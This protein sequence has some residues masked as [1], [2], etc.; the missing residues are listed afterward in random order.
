MKSIKRIS[1]GV[2]ALSALLGTLFI[3]AS[4]SSVQAQTT[5][6]ISPNTAAFRATAGNAQT[7]L[8][9]ADGSAQSADERPIFTVAFTSTNCDAPLGGTIHAPYSSTGNVALG[10]TNAA[11][12]PI[13]THINTN[14]TSQSGTGADACRYTLRITSS[15]NCIITVTNNPTG[16]SNPVPVGTQAKDTAT[17]S[18]TNAI[19]VSL[20]GQTGLSTGD[21]FRRAHAAPITADDT[22]TPE[23]TAES[24]S[25]AGGGAGLL[26]LPTGV[27]AP[28][29]L[30]LA[31][32]S[33]TALA[34]VSTM[35]GLTS[36]VVGGTD[37]DAPPTLTGRVAVT[38]AEPQG[39]LNLGLS[40]EPLSQCQSP[41]SGASSYAAGDNSN[42]AF[43][44]LNQNCRY[45]LRITPGTGNVIDVATN[46]LKLQCGVG[47]VIY[48]NS[49]AT[50]LATGS[51]G[52]TPV[53]G[54]AAEA[55]Q[56]R[57]SGSTLTLGTGDSPPQ[58]TKIVLFVTTSCP[59]VATTNLAFAVDSAVSATVGN[60]ASI[61]ATIISATAGCVASP[62]SVTITGAGVVRNVGFIVRPRNGSACQYQVTYPRF[63]GALSL[64]LEPGGSIETVGGVTTV[65]TT[66]NNLDG[67]I[68]INA[69]QLQNVTTTFTYTQRQLDITV[70]TTF[71]DGLVFRTTDTVKYDVSIVGPCSRFP[72]IVARALAN[73]SE[74]YSVQADSGTVI[75]LN[76]Q[77]RTLQSANNQA[78]DLLYEVAPVIIVDNNVV[79][80]TVQVRE[81][82]TP[83]GCVVVT[84]DNGGATKVIEF[85]SGLN[86]FAFDFEH[87][88]TGVE[89][90]SSRGF[91][92]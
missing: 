65:T 51:A 57:F 83:T 20:T 86:A 38:N 30:A 27:P 43:L 75:V 79:N 72:S 48:S 84:D 31:A 59:A 74:S 80:C 73:T 17:G 45:E 23:V 10:V 36:F 50:T 40:I 77:L 8:A 42:V 67:I 14:P 25:V 21:F 87:T 39:S 62:A 52:V 18:Q 90:L 35:N 56:L 85:A 68:A 34:Y 12:I 54:D 60:Q 49:D 41:T 64:Q 81:T 28:G 29:Q 13:V 7:L 26:A 91:T 89:T 15:L 5:T 47:A 55:L 76:K 66:D 9:I 37:C 44:E 92:G 19:S 70:Q 63:S 24:A 6:T 78:G 71:P 69:L 61:T 3:T 53:S 4:P 82:G 33:T 11:A 58:I 1:V 16:A 32:S 46:A 22:V 88:C 2:L